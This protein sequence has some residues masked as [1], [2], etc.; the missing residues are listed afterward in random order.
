MKSSLISALRPRC[1]FHYST[2]S[3]AAVEELTQACKSMERRY[4]RE[5]DS[6][7]PYIIRLDGAHFKRLT[8]ALVKPFDPHFTMAM[9][10][11]AAD[12]LDHFAAMTVFVQSDEVSLFM[13]PRWGPVPYNGRCQKIASVAAG[14]ASSRFNHHFNGDQLGYFD[15][16]VF[17]C[18]DDHQLTRVAAWRHLH[19]CRRNAVNSAAAANFHHSTLQNQPVDVV[20]ER[21]LVER[22]IRFHEDYPKEAILGAF[23]KKMRWERVG[24]DPI[25]GESVVTTRFRTQARA[26]DFAQYPLD[27]LTQ[28]LTSR[29]WEPEHPVGHPIDI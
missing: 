24:Y 26:I 3:T 17:S 9:I 22:K 15:A 16:R 11:T 7:C 5:L 8:A 19:D 10:K 25:R 2:T 13:S 20:I 18:A 21:L 4:E 28:V 12:L 29:Y 23:L 14:F 27:T 6:G 1:R